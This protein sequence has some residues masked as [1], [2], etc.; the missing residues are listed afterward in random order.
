MVRGSRTLLSTCLP[1]VAEESNTDGKGWEEQ[2]QKIW[3]NGI[4]LSLH[5]V[6]RHLDML[7]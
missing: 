5:I 7:V 2:K 6:R 1:R 3:L 4:V